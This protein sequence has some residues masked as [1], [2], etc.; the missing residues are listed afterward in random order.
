[1][2]T[3]LPASMAPNLAYEYLQD[4]AAHNVRY[5]EFFWNPTGTARQSGIAYPLALQ[6]IVRAI[7]DAQRRHRHRLQRGR[8][9]AGVVLRCVC[10]GTGP[11]CMVHNT[12]YGFND[13]ILPTTASFWVTL[14]QAYLA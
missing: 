4:A 11:G 13:E 8:S 5:A 3:P 7:A 9:P 10:G 6:A 1:M 2:T 14:T 12:D